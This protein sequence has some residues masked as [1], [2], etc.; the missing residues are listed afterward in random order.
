VKVGV[1]IPAYNVLPFIET[2]LTTINTQTWASS[3]YIVDDCSTDGTYEFLRDRPGWYRRLGRNPTRQGW[4]KTL[5]AAGR[6][7]LADGCD[8]VFTMNADDFL[9]L[10]CIEQCV[11]LLARHDWV[12]ANAQQVGGENVVQAC[13]EHATLADFATWPPITNYALIPSPIW[14][15]MDGYASDVTVPGSYG[16]AEDWDFWVRVLK[17]GHTDYGVVTQPTYY[18]RMRAGQLHEGRAQIHEAGRALLYAKH[19]DLG[20]IAAERRP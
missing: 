11:R 14:A 4:P 8:A 7:A 16:A 19:P 13:A 3:A 5:N 18:Y 10:D 2:C 15:A 1:I 12:V 20:K 17:A 6:L 9:R